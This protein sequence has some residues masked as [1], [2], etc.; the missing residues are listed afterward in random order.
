MEKNEFRYRLGF[1]FAVAFLMFAAL[2][3]GYM[4]YAIHQNPEDFLSGFGGGLIAPLGIAMAIYFRRRRPFRPS[5][6]KAL[7]M[8]TS[9]LIYTQ[10]V[11]IMVAICL[12]MELPY[13]RVGAYW[14]RNDAYFVGA[15]VLVFG[16]IVRIE[17]IRAAV[18]RRREAAETA[19]ASL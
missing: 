13:W 2:C 17:S 10:A 19:Q 5:R 15:V 14:Q 12:L 8:L 1:A 18:R 9:A 6:D 11:T 3:R 16:A 4:K 7:N